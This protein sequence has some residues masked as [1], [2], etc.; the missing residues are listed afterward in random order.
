MVNIERTENI[1]RY[2]DIGHVHSLKPMNISQK[3][4]EKASVRN[5]SGMFDSKHSFLLSF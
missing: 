5:K 3:S 4:V 1:Q 2:L